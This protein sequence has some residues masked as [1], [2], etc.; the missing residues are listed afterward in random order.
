MKEGGKEGPYAFILC[1]DRLTIFYFLHVSA[2]VAL[3]RTA[4]RQIKTTKSPLSLQ[5]EEQRI[6]H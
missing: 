6:F 1:V 4:N 3:M 2:Q 5:L